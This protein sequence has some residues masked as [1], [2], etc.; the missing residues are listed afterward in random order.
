MNIDWRFH[1]RKFVTYWIWNL[2][3]FKWI[4]I[5]LN[6]FLLHPKTEMEKIKKKKVKKI[7][8]LPYEKLMALFLSYTQI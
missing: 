8:T 6:I 2:S 1:T 3:H 5:T 4:E 7:K